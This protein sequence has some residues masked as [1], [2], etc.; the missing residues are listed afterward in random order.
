MHY[1]VKKSFYSS[2]WPAFIF[3]SWVSIFLLYLALAEALSI[4]E[5]WHT[6]VSQVISP[7][8]ENQNLYFSGTMWGQ[9]CHELKRIRSGFRI[10]RHYAIQDI[11][12][13]SF[14]CWHLNSVSLWKQESCFSLCHWD[15]TVMKKTS[16]K[17][18]PFD[19][20]TW[21][22]WSYILLWFLLIIF[23]WLFSSPE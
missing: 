17:D 3:S 22:S 13:L 1:T 8:T 18:V 2:S 4:D 11:F 10:G 15:Q 20:T 9:L 5:S 12:L 23:F 14:A 7:G 21:L 19:G 6:I 16:H